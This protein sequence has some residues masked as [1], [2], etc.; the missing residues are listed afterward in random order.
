MDL[1]LTTLCFLFLSNFIFPI[2]EPASLSI[3][4]DKEALISFMSTLTFEPPNNPLSNWNLHSSSP[5]N[6]T[7]VACSQSSSGHQRVEALDLSNFGISGSISPHI[8]NLSFLHSLQL[9]KNKLRGTLPDQIFTNLNRLRLLNISSNQIQ[10]FLPSNITHLKDLQVLDLMGNRITGKIPESFSFL[11]KLQVLNLGKN[12]L[13]GPIPPSFSNLSSLTSLNLGTNTLSGFIPSELGRLR[14]LKELD[15]TINNLA[16]TIP[17]SIYNLSSLVH[18]AVASNQLWGEIPYDIGY[19]LPN[20]LIFNFCINKFT[21]KIPG[22]LHNLTRIQVIRMAH[23]LLEGPVPPGLGNLPSLQM[24]NIGYNKI[25]GSLSFLSSLSNS[26]LLKFLAIDGNLFEG[27]IPDSIG[28]LSNVLSKLY[29]GQNRIYGKIPK[30]IGHLRSLTLLNL[31][32]N[33]VSGEI[34]TEIGELKE[35]QVLVLGKNKLSGAIP[36]SLGNLQ[37]LNEIDLSGNSLLGF[38]PKSFESFQSLLSMDLSSNKL[39][40]SIPKESLNLPSLSTL[41]NLSNNFLSGPLPEEIGLLENLVSIDLSNNQL[42]GSISSSIKNCKS[43]E[44]LFMAENRFSGPI[45]DDIG[46]VKGLEML[47]LSSNQ[48]TGSI[49]ED[50]S[51]LKALKFLNLSFNNLEGEVPKDGVFKDISSVHLEGNQKLCLKFPCPNKKGDGKRLAKILAIA[52]ILV[53]SILSLLLGLFVYLRKKKAKIPQLS[54]PFKGYHQMVSYE[55]LQQ[56]TGN[57]SRENFIGEGSFG[58]VYKGFLREGI[59]VAVKVLNAQMKAS[60]KSFEA[61][62]EALR[63]VRHRN[64]VKLITSC[65]S[66]DFKNKEFLA[67]VYEF[68]ANGSLDDWIKGKRKKENGEGLSFLE[69]LN[70]AI[71]VASALDYLHHDCVVPVVHC[72]IKPSNVVLDEDMTAKVGDFGLARLLLEKSDGQISISSTHVLK[73]SIGY[74]PPEYGIGEK[75]ST[76][77]DAYSFGVM[78]LELFT[79]KSPTHESFNGELNLAMWV[80]S[81]YPQNML[82]VIDPQLLNQQVRDPNDQAQFISPEKQHSCLATV[83]EIGLACTG[84]SADTRMSMRHALHNLKSAKHTLLKETKETKA[85]P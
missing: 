49:P 24:Y 52:A 67:L 45:P 22:S 83:I 13:S 34:P 29:M 43:L 8:G 64:L 77:G 18:L 47:D 28:N 54:E 85:S 9:Q 38:V 58:S 2:A 62:C 25:V 6:W 21:G 75:P 30:T 20:L 26:T 68:L 72:D 4:T 84:Y 1:Q 73:G 65:S 53:T 10:G 7:G 69:R 32:S 61:E 35:L 60:W 44:G 36:N 82:Q 19:R 50:L 76:A 57:F 27:V 39:N 55:E 11:T 56:A 59:A 16:G 31:S 42:S 74:I 17:S 37:K 78:L 41:L 3:T 71:D 70:A 81:A 46:E 15:I 40:G 79:G 80:H 33:S 12:N 23:N 63:N 14:N 5:C 51:K 66:I 48:L